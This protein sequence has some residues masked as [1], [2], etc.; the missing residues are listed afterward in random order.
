MIMNRA[1]AAAIAGIAIVAGPAWG[2]SGAVSAGPNPGTSALQGSDVGALEEIT[3]TAR[4]REERQQDVP[5]A[6]TALSGDFL[7][8]NAVMSLRDL[9]G[10]VPSLQIESYNSPLYTNI[11]IRGQRNNNVAPGQDPAVGYYFSEVS[12][13]YPVGINEQLFDLQSLEVVKGPQG[14]LF[15]RNTTGGGVL[16][17]PAKPTGQ[18]EGSLTAGMT[19]FDHGLGFYTTDVVNLPL[20][21]ILSFRVAVNLISHDGYVKNLITPEQVDAFAINPS[22]G[23]GSAADPDD[24]HSKA[25]RISALFKPAATVDSYF[26]FQGSEYRD[27]GMAYSLTALSPAGYANYALS[28]IGVN[29]VQ[30]YQTRQAQQASDFWSTDSGLSAYNRANDLAGSNT[31]TWTPMDLF[32]VKNI[33]GYRRFSVEQAIPLDGMPYQILD[34]AFS[35]EGSEYSDEL[36]FQGKTPDDLFN[37]VAGYYFFAQYLE[38]PRETL[39]LPEFG[40]PPSHAQEDVGNKSNAEFAQG[41]M[42][43]PWLRDLSFTAGVRNTHDDR[44][45]TS[46]SY[47][48][49]GTASC[50]LTGV[51]NCEFAGDVGYNVVTYNLSLDYKIDPDT[52][53]Y[54]A[55]RKGY[56]AGGW[57]Y[58]GGPTPDTF[59]PFKPEFVNDW[60]V[61]LKRDWHFGP[62]SLRSNLAV[63]RSRLTDAQQLLS[64]ATNPNL[65][66]VINAA[67]ATINGGELELTYV[68]VKGLEFS[69]FVSIIDAYFNSFVYGGNNFTNNSFA[70]TPKTQ[71]EVRGK[72]DLPLE[73]ALGTISVEADYT[74]QSHIYFTVDA[75]GSEWGPTSSQGQNG[76]GILDVRLDWHSIMQS[77]FDAAFYIKNATATEY[78][79]FGVILYTSLGYNVATIGQPRIFGLEGTYRF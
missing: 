57:N 24:E 60:E 23:P 4:R 66:E 56:R 71:Y 5:L 54:V 15:G 26:L 41:T 73:P 10:Q 37:W 55:R 33:V 51:S 45:M 3:V 69:S 61:G 14:T 9:N 59:G 50:A 52:L 48:S 44:R 19:G 43:L 79:A 11:G 34:S 12:Y 36:Q 32:T 29:G 38:H 46:Q 42:K 28:L 16:I 53:V 67:S 7:K 63:Y 70:Q 17:T 40:T 22:F 62:S 64:P 21:D 68:P 47:N 78:N 20:N 1:A 31:T 74:H 6:I 39:A 8:Q 13:S 49:P 30:V 25:F 18:F 58:V 27:S 75:Q 2:D 77:K 76:Y 72:Y 65:F 35:D